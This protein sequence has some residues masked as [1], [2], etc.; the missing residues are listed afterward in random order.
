MESATILTPLESAYAVFCFP[1][2]A[3]IPQDQNMKKYQHYMDV[4]GEVFPT[5]RCT[6]TA[7]ATSK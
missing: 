7:V 1:S 6:T 4:Q 3:N 5:P 2:E